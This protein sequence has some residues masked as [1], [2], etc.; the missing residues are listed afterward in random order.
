MLSIPVDELTPADYVRII[1]EVASI[2]DP[3]GIFG[4][5]AAYSHPKCSTIFGWLMIHSVNSLNIVI[6]S[7][8][9]QNLIAL[10]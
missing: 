5:I 1:A 8:S 6:I 9:I 2:F 4:V 7:N 3:T 10:L